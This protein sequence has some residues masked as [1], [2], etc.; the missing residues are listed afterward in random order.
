MRKTAVL[1]ALVLGMVQ[2][3]RAQEADT[4]SNRQLAVEIAYRLDRELGEIDAAQRHL[5]IWRL[6]IARADGELAVGEPI[7]DSWLEWLQ[8]IEQLERRLEL[9]QLPVW[10]QPARPDEVTALLA[11]EVP[12]IEPLQWLPSIGSRQLAVTGTRLLT[13]RRAVLDASAQYPALLAWAR[14]HSA[15][16][17][18]ELLDVLAANPELVPLFEP[19]FSSWLALPLAEPVSV[20]RQLKDQA[21]LELDRLFDQPEQSGNPLIALAA[22]IDELETPTVRHSSADTWRLSLA[23]QGLFLNR[24]TADDLDRALLSLAH[25]VRRIEYGGFQSLVEPL[26]SITYLVIMRADLIDPQSRIDEVLGQ[27]GRM[28]QWL[29]PQIG[30]IDQ[31][32][33]SVYQQL[34]LLLRDWQRK[35]RTENV[36][37]RGLK[38]RILAAL[39]ASLELTATD[40]EG[41][42]SQ[43]FREALEIKLL[44][45][46]GQGIAQP[47]FPAVPINQQDFLDCITYF[48]AWANRD[49]ATPEMAGDSAGRF[50]VDHLQRELGMIPAQRINY[51]YGF[52]GGQLG[53]NCEAPDKV[54]LVN[55]F[56]WALAARAFVWLADRWPAYFVALNVQQHT[57]RLI[58]TGHLLVQAMNRLK[59]CFRENSG[60]PLLVLIDQYRQSLEATAAAIDQATADFRTLQ[61]KQG[62]DVK[63][64]GDAS[65]T[66][67]YRPTDRPVGACN[68]QA[69][70]DM[71]DKLEATRALYDLFPGPYQIADQIGLG[72][73]SLCYANVQWVERRAQV[74][75]ARIQAMANYFAR[76]SFELQGQYAGQQKPVFRMR[77]VGDHEY[78]YLFGE[79]SLKVLN[80]P[81]PRELIGTQVRAKLPKRPIQLVPRRLTYMTADRK[82][83]ARVFDQHWTHGDGWRDWFVTDGDVEV[84]EVNEEN[85]LELVNARLQTLNSSWNREVYR[86]MLEGDDGGLIGQSELAAAMRAL[87]L[88]KRILVTVAS[89]LLPERIKTE[90]ALR[91]SL[92]GHE[93]LFGRRAALQMRSKEV[94]VQMAAQLARG[95]LQ[96][97]QYLWQG[98]ASNS[99]TRVEQTNSLISTTLL[100]LHALG[101][102]Y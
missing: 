31:N 44:I 101:D 47:P 89:L 78:E 18:V 35:P 26:A 51:W 39:N 92:F 27:L 1:L 48:V 90:A 70:C 3:I 52:V 11:S 54:A 61:L 23:R 96:D 5:L 22:E 64:D 46:F 55:P 71:S 74:P 60:D 86:Q 75:S 13:D 97:A 94:P 17:W 49:S 21:K 53:P 33:L 43:P 42:L 69:S 81:C 4:G 80:N 98:M 63:L 16:I 91:E 8:T 93:G 25:G 28:D 56:E 67:R 15:Q 24:D 73:V 79:N 59:T 62:A 12:E 84:L 77:L 9:T 65:Q 66:T 88:R 82:H 50:E 20:W 32:V 7:G 45:C 19:L 14:S 2:S 36:Q 30:K 57:Q 95:H 102:R 6:L 100:E 99:A 10:H 83:P 38:L 40:L 76:L 68:Q 58:G 72:D 41:Y 34:R 37:Y 29:L 85:L 87:D